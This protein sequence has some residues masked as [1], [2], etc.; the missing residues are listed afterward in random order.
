MSGVVVAVAVGSSTGFVAATPDPTF[1][2]NNQ[3]FDFMVKV[4]LGVIKSWI[5]NSYPR[6]Q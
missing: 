2:V 3:L 6:W 1:I 5:M 4:R